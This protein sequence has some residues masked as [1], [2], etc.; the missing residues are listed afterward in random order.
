LSKDSTNK[1]IRLDST[2]DEEHPKT[3]YLRLHSREL[4]NLSE[5][6][7]YRRAQLDKLQTKSAI[8]I[9]RFWRFYLFMRRKVQDEFLR[10]LSLDNE[11][12]ERLLRNE[13]IREELL[14][15]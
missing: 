6:P 11:S 14:Q 13:E 15:H 12:L 9:Q 10:R 2:R 1:S 3:S 7:A 8:R 4:K 5:D